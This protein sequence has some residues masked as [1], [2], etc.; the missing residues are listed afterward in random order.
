MKRLASLTLLVCLCAGCSVVASKSNY[1]Q[2]YKRFRDTANAAC[3]DLFRAMDAGDRAGV[4][5]AVGRLLAAKPPPDLKRR[6][7]IYRSDV[8]TY[9]TAR[10]VVS[11]RAA[12]ALDDGAVELGLDDC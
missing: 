7:Q 10:K 6:W 4:E 12:Y 1:P 9:F 8:R 11:E 3:K 2:Q 5:A